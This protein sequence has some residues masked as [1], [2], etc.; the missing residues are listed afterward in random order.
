[1]RSSRGFKLADFLATAIFADFANDKRGKRP[2]THFD[3]HSHV[4]ARHR[5][6]RRA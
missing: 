5:L 2:W 4:V 6:A 3:A 1:M